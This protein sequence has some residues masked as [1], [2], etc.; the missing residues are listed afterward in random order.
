MDD[1]ECKVGYDQHA[2]QDKGEDEDEVDELGVSVPD[3]P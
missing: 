1:K 2:Q 3:A